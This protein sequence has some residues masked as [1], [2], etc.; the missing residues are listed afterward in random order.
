MATWGSQIDHKGSGIISQFVAGNFMEGVDI[1][2][3][4]LFSQ[5]LASVGTNLHLSSLN[6]HLP[7][8]MGL[9]LL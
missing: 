3:R 8:E 6:S 1:H 9:H 7:W 5:H 2:C 4:S